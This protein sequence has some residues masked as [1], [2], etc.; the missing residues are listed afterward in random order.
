MELLLVVA[1]AVLA[2]S[3]S[4]PVF[5]RSARVTQLRASA[6]TVIMA[7]RYARGLS[8]LQ[9]THAAV[10][11]D[12]V[13]GEIE[14]VSVRAGAG[15]VDREA[16]LAGRTH[17]SGLETGEE[18]SVPEAAVESELIRN[19]AAGV[20]IEEINDRVPERVQ[21]VNYYPNGMC[22]RYN[23]TLVDRSGGRATVSVD[24]FSGSVEAKYE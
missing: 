1:I 12:S 17:R 22:D 6:R 16:F 23:I 11:F 5:V 8:V 9:R 20:R 4:V 24:P 3:I 15:T 10:L 19:L 2:T 21:W 7:H 18:L 14:V 13:A